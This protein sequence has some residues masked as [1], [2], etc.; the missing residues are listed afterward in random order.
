MPK[1]LSAKQKLYCQNIVKGLTQEKAYIEAGYS[2]NSAV[3]AA[4]RLLQNVEVCRYIDELQ[5]PAEDAIRLT[6]AI[7]HKELHDIVTGTAAPADK[8]RAIAEF[9]KMSGG[10][11]P[12]K[13]EVKSGLMIM[14]DR[15]RDSQEAKKIGEER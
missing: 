13:V 1:E 6:V 14:L 7:A 9:N 2:E 8:I 3:K 15:I 4:S 11:E 5:Q 12:E 10:Y